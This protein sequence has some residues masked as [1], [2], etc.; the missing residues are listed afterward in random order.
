MS[1]DFTFF[2]TSD[3]ICIN[4]HRG[5]SVVLSNLP[6]DPLYIKRLKSREKTEIVW[7]KKMKM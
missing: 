6:I 2:M 5:Q 7:H 1:I 3:R 4:I